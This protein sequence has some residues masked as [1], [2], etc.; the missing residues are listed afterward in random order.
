MSSQQRS[1]C[2]PGGMLVVPIVLVHSQSIKT[3]NCTQASETLS[4]ASIMDDGRCQQCM[5]FRNTV[6]LLL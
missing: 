6:N 2:S 4:S 5:A 1:V 3:D